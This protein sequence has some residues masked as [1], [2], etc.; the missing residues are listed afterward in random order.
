MR[1][2][3]QDK[4]R[5][6]GCDLTETQAGIVIDRL[7]GEHAIVAVENT[8]GSGFSFSVSRLEQL[9]ES[10]ESGE[11][12]VENMDRASTNELIAERPNIFG[13]VGG[14]CTTSDNKGINAAKEVAVN[15]VPPVVGS[16]PGNDLNGVLLGGHPV[17][18][19]RWTTT[20]W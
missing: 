2:S 12:I 18:S 17:A 10:L 8:V 4:A 3:I 6:W 11:P 1:S 9:L 20:L 14:Y 19:R 5:P 7:R 16:P 13:D 15:E